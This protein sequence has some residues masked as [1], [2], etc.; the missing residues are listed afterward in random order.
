MGSAQ[1]IGAYGWCAVYA[2][3]LGLAIV[4]GAVFKLIFG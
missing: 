2:S 4:A 3:V 1:R